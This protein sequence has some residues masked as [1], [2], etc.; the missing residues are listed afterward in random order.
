MPVFMAANSG[1]KRYIGLLIVLALALLS[2]WFQQQERSLEVSPPRDSHVVDYAMRDFE[3]TAMDDSGVPRHR[4]EAVS[5]VH[6]GDDDSAELQQPRLLLYRSTADA[7]TE[8]WSLQAQQ[9][10][11]YRGGEEMLLQGGV[12]LQRLD[13]K[14]QVTL[15]LETEELRAFPDQE[16]AETAAA[17][18]IRERHGIT[19]A[20]GLKIDLKAGQIELLAAVRGEYVRE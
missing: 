17:V 10:W 7:A 1:S 18:A 3:V 2:W 11:L 5:M 15:A 12:K 8:R 9:A 4:I 13:A 19:R 16:R 6:Y 14:E 20:Q